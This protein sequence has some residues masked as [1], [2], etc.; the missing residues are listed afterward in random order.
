MVGFRGIVVAAFVF[1]G[2]CGDFATNPIGNKGADAGTE[3]DASGSGASLVFTFSTRPTLPDS[4]DGDDRP[5]LTDARFVVKDFR[6]I[7]DSSDGEDTS[8]R[9][10]TLVWDDVSSP[11][12]L[13]FSRAPTGN[14]S[15]I[16]GEVS[17]FE[18]HGTVMGSDGR[19]PFRIVD[20]SA[21]ISMRESIDVRLDPE[22]TERVEV[23]LDLRDLVDDVKWE[24]VDPVDGVLLLDESAEEFEEV[25][26]ELEEIF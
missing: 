21:R 13:R 16:L 5:I 19:Q 22:T 10:L 7:G 11:E 6:V 25:V 17:A 20:E 23:K 1:S 3:P 2:G 15:T 18:F 12:D 24:D 9:E 14:Y 4:V 8:I 26:D